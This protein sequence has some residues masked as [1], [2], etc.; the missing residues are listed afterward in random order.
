LVG[1]TGYITR[2]IGDDQAGFL[3]FFFREVRPRLSL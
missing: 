2:Q 3:D 1:I